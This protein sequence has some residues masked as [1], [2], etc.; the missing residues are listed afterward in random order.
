M[1]EQVL[2]AE[3]LQAAWRKVKANAGAPGIDG[4]VSVHMLLFSVAE[5]D[6]SAARLV[7]HAGFALFGFCVFTERFD[8]CQVFFAARCALVG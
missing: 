3:N 1:M 5:R 6:K 4:M 8:V 7:A 2:A